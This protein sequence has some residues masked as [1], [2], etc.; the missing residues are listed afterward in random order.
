MA[1]ASLEDFLSCPADVGEVGWVDE[2]GEELKVD[3]IAGSCVRGVRVER[4]GACVDLLGDLVA[5]RDAVDGM[6]GFDADPSVFAYVDRVVLQRRATFGF[7]D[8]DWNRREGFAPLAELHL[9]A[10]RVDGK[11]WD[12]DDFFAGEVGGKSGP[13]GFQGVMGGGEERV[14]VGSHDGVPAPRQAS[15]SGAATQVHRGTSFDQDGWPVGAESGGEE[16]FVDDD[17]RKAALNTSVDLADGARDCVAARAVTSDWAAAPGPRRGVRLGSRPLFYVSAKRVSR[18]RVEVSLTKR[19]V[20]GLAKQGGVGAVARAIANG[21]GGFDQ[22]ES[23]DS[24]TSSGGRSRR[25]T[26]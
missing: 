22:G 2:R 23:V 18:G 15:R 5:N 4:V 26:R 13:P 12:V 10:T 9:E 17:G 24:I 3:Q 6:F 19:G 11:P 8:L 25:H 20:D 1:S 16:Q 14:E 21:R 7:G